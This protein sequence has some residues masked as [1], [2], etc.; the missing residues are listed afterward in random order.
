MLHT[1]RAA[2]LQQDSQLIRRLHQKSCIGLVAVFCFA[3]VLAQDMPPLAAYGALPRISLVTLSPDGS[4]VA[5]R[6]KSG[7]TDAISIIDL[8]TQTFLTG[9]RTD[10]I[11]PD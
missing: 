10:N 5:M 9:A 6:V 1:P 8:A 4:K 11:N 3:G 2:T 7:D